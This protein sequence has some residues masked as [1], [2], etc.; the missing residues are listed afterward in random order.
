MSPHSHL[1]QFL[2]TLVIVALVGVALTSGTALA[3]SETGASGNVVVEAGETVDEVNAFA[4]NVRIEGTVTGDVNAVAGN[5]VVEDGGEVGGD[6]NGV[7]GTIEIHGHVGGDVAAAAG[8]LEVGETGT[9]DGVLEAGAGTI[10]L[11]GTIAGDV[12]VGAEVIT[13]GET[14]SLEGDLRYDGDLEGN[15]D[16]V[17]GDITRDSTL[18]VDIAPVIVPL[19]TWVAAAYALAANLLLG[20]I[21]LALFPR[22]SDGVA[23]RVATDPLR[24]GAIGLVALVGIPILLVAIAITV[25]GIPIALVGM[26]AFALFVWVGIVYGRFAVAAWALSLIDV[27]NRWLA[28]VVGLVAGAFLTLV[29]IVGWF[30]NLL[31]TVLGLGALAGGLVA[32]RRRVSQPESDTGVTEA[33]SGPR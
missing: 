20:A 13:L 21:L 16:A 23:A 8:T 10:V 30:L 2:V 18:G 14:A 15:T 17:A 25:I 7:A 6:L 19:A 5:V 4:G 29:P 22:F 9:V 24:T 27:R 31:I 3:Q 26:L 33:A 12:T 11:D 28:L 32:H 1:H